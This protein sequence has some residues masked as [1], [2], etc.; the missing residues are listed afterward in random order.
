MAA[1]LPN[2]QA[3]LTGWLLPFYTQDDLNAWAAEVL[4]EPEAN[5]AI[6]ISF[7]QQARIR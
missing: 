4:R 2:L 6:G 3:V 7:D 5:L 1:R